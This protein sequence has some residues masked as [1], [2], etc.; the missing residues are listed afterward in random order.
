[1]SCSDLL[2]APEKT[3]KRLQSRVLKSSAKDKMHNFQCGMWALIMATWG[4]RSRSFVDYTLRSALPAPLRAYVH[5]A[6]SV[7]TRP[8]NAARH[9]A[10]Q[11]W[12]AMGHNAYQLAATN[13]AFQ[14]G[15]P[16]L[17]PI[18]FAG[19][20]ITDAG[21]S[22]LAE[23]LMFNPALQRLDLSCMSAPHCFRPEQLALLIGAVG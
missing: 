19:N 22:A 13:E 12:R 11:G 14:R 4:T 8:S 5:S 16:V 18:W 9:S 1:M 20:Q 21:A 17:T 23:G 2:A 6:T 7:V 3:D 10:L 15:P